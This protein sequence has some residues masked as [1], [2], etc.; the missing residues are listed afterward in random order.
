[1]KKDTEYL[2]EVGDVEYIGAYMNDAFGSSGH[3]HVFRAKLHRPIG[4]SSWLSTSLAT[5]W[6]L[7]SAVGKV[8]KEVKN[9]GY[10]SDLPKG[11]VFVD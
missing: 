10:S 6:R 8:I 7:V 9:S 3:Y 4:G 5:N 11:Y 1:M 2:F